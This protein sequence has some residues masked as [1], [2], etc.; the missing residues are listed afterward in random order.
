MGAPSNGRDSHET[1]KDFEGVSPGSC[2]IAK[3]L[4]KMVWK[5]RRG[6]EGKQTHESQ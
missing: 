5:N 4:L 6:V 1:Y 2:A 3:L